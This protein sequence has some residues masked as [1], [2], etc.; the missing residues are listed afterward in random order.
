LEGIPELQGGGI[1]VT[2]GP[3]S[4]VFAVLMGLTDDVSDQ[5]IEEV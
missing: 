5:H 4:L 1:Q 3:E 2:E